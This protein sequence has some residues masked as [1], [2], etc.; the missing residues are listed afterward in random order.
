MDSSLRQQAID[1]INSNHTTIKN[2]PRSFKNKLFN[3]NKKVTVVTA[4]YNA[5][6]FISKSI[7]SVI[8]QTI[9]F[10]Y[11]QY[12][13]VDDC[14]TDRTPEIIEEY[15]AQYKNIC[16]VSLDKNTGSPGLPRN[17]GIEL[18]TS[19]YVTFLDADDWLDESG[20][21]VLYN[22]L[23]ESD[24]D[25]I[26]GK[27]I[28]VESKGNS[29]I[30]E[31]ASVMERRNVSPFSIPHFFYHMGPTAKMMKLSLLDKYN[32]RFPDMKFAEDKLF[33]IEV[34]VHV[35]SVS[36]TISPVYYVN[37][38]NENVNSLTRITDVLDKRKSDLK[39]INHVKSLNL[40]IDKERVI[41]NR[42]YEYDI[43][44]TFDSYLFVKS[45]EK[46]GFLDILRDAIV[47]T[48]D[49]RYDFKEDIKF[50][51]FQ[52]AINLFLDGREDDFTKLFEW[53]KKD[54]NKMQILKN[55]IAYYEVPFLMDSYQ[56]I[57]IP[58]L[59]RTLDS[60][61]INNKYIQ[62]FEVYGDYIDNINA[63]IIRDRTNFD[64]E[65]QCDF[66]VNGNIGQ[67]QVHFKDLEIL[68]NSLFTVFIRY[69][70]YQLINI[71]RTLKNQ[72]TRNN[73]H[74]SFYTS[75]ANNLGLS[76]KPKS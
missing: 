29:V 3:S 15:A 1:C 73:K 8:N 65:I 40:S 10:K 45:D 32:I 57:K 30:G 69:N 37:R 38:T 61:V 16:F 9:D 26:V 53:F 14:S 5:E 68:Q 48:K 11:I 22:I 52:T 19:K 28:K 13:I 67:F 36:T 43:L 66:Q 35:N 33:F 71:K 18:A 23:E 62:T 72:V 54:K 41:L 50:P 25:Y 60:Y 76:I 4:S 31:Y 59:A 12:I 75:V 58:L 51:L 70:D 17:I 7:E 6:E 55:D 47:T 39:V 49:L 46:N 42:I 74:F 56:F 64:N 44:R 20:I 21:E 34:F 63:I 2:D 27:T 24:D